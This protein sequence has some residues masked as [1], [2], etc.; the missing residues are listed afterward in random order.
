MSSSFR[1]AAITLYIKLTRYL[2]WDYLTYLNILQ[3]NSSYTLLQVQ[4]TSICIKGNSRITN[5]MS[6]TSFAKFVKLLFIISS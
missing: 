1:N 4:E 3:N 2:V 6:Y 5:Q